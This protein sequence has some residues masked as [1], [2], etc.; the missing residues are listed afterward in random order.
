MIFYN[1]WSIYSRLPKITNPLGINRGLI[2]Y[3]AYNFVHSL[4]FN[5]ILIDNNQLIVPRL[6]WM[7][8]KS[9]RSPAFSNTWAYCTMPFRSITNEALLETPF[10]L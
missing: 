1:Y 8:S 2:R 6:A 4:I 9:G 7:A 3:S 5:L 10:I